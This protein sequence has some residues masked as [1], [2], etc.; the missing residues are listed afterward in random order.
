MK[1]VFAVAAVI[2]S[3]HSFAQDSI[4][5]NDQ[6][7]LDRV[8]ITTNKYPRK[9]SQTGKVVSV[10]DRTTLDQMGGRTLGEILTTIS[11][12]TINGANNN[13][14]TNQRISIRGASDG[15]V[16]LLVDGIPVNDPSVISNYFDLNFFHPSQIERIEVLKGGQSTL[17]GSD[18]VAGVINIITRRQASR[19]AI[20]FASASYGSYGTFNGTA[21]I[22]G[23]GENFQYNLAYTYNGSK[24]FSAAY[25]TSA[26]RKDRDGF[27]QHIVRADLGLAITKNLYWNIL[28]STSSYQADIDAAAY[29]N[30]NDFTIENKNF[31]AGTG[32]TWKHGR[33]S[34]RLNYQYNHIDRFY[35]DDSTDRASFSYYS[36]SNYIGRTHF[37]EL[38]ENY[39]WDRFSLL[40]GIDHRIYN[41]TQEYRSLSMFG[42]YDSRLDDTAR[43]WQTSPYA[44]LVYDHN[45]LNIEIGGR[46]NHHNL[47]GNNFTFTFNPSLLVKEKIK[48]FANLSSAFKTPSLYQLFDPFIGNRAL[49]PERTIVIEAGAELYQTNLVA[50][51]TPFYHRTSN[52]IQFI[53]TDPVFF[54]G[55]YLNV[56]SQENY[57]G[58]FELNYRNTSWNVNANYT[59]TKG[60]ISSDYTESGGQLSK[61]TTYNNLYRVPEHAFNIFAS[62]KLT[63]NISVSSMV[64][65]SGSRLEPVYADIPAELDAY[66]T[67]DLSGQYR[68]NEKL[69]A[70]VDLRNITN[71][72]YFD[73]LGYHSRR[74]NFTA[75]FDVQF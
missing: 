12:T 65:Y 70:F 39:R 17:Y 13:A 40:A 59:F 20:P 57:G 37:A 2:F 43:M 66:M 21:G 3:S 29:T 7:P 61:D 51:V 22:R 69:R 11:G 58:E 26:G 9:Q 33:G 67:I 32:L 38:Y 52:A 50:R 6:Q 68:F 27:R 64:R 19:K 44:S 24:G 53:I 4:L 1:R 72:K 5:N 15:N 74:F 34:L 60:R 75:G 16:L 55:K 71:K 63:Q 62:R 8:V 47:Y 23:R 54:S 14:G 49:D 42:P 25:D 10:I 30:D 41:T 46:W 48:L 35:L 28:G 31:Q 73:I 36:R 56:N 18:A 45:D